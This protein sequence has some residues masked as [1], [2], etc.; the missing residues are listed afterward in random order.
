MTVPNAIDPDVETSGRWR[1]LAAYGAIAAANQMLSFAFA[2]ILSEVAKIYEIEPVIAGL[3]LVGVF[4]LVFVLLSVPAGRIADRFG[5]R[6]AVLTGA[7]VMSLGAAG[8]TLDTWFLALLMGQLAIAVAQPFLFN[9]MPRL[10]AD[11]FPEGQR[12]TAT[13]LATS[14]F[15]L[16]LGLGLGVTAPLI[17]W[18][19]FSGTMRLFAFVTI[20]ATSFGVLTI[21]PN[22]RRAIAES[23]AA[24][25]LTPPQRWACY[26]LYA[27]GFFLVGYFNGLLTWIEALVFRL[28]LDSLTAGVAGGAFVFAGMV[29]AGVIPKWADMMGDSRSWMRLGSASTVLLTIPLLWVPLPVVV[30]ASAALLGFFFLPMAALVV[31]ALSA[32]V[33][34][35]A[36]AS[37]TARFMLIGNLGAIATTICM[38]KLGNSVDGFSAAAW[39]LLLVSSAGAAT[40]FS[41][42]RTM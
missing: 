2:P 26:T 1:V 36:A 8:L 18:V 11:W 3:L 5:H 4:P 38:G 13:G 9:A 6:V 20:G 14:G 40:A 41:V 30:I 16:G 37:A 33:G 12:R 19:G 22:P 32:I 7:A 23:D 34:E 42:R 21:K 31:A 17:A 15:Y 10:I 35:R 25:T 28:G 24:A 29:G 27:M 39:L